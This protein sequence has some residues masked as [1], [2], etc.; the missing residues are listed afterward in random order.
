MPVD[1]VRALNSNL[2]I[3]YF[4]VVLLRAFA[5]ASIEDG[6]IFARRTS[7]FAS[8]IWTEKAFAGSIRQKLSLDRI[9]RTLTSTP[10]KS[11]FS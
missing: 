7:K 1:I 6:F 2:V 11:S 3:G 9:K 5:W 10:F 4:A 8:S